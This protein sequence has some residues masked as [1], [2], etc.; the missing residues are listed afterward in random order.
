MYFING[1]GIY[2]ESSCEGNFHRLSVQI[3]GGLLV[4]FHETRGFSIRLVQYLHALLKLKKGCWINLAKLALGG[5][6][7]SQKRDF[8]F[9][10]EEFW[11]AR[12]EEFS[13]CIKLLMH[14]KPSFQSDF[15][16]VDVHLLVYSFSSGM[17]LGEIS[18]AMFVVRS[19]LTSSTSLVCPRVHISFT[20]A[21][22]GSMSSS[23]ITP[24]AR[25]SRPV[26]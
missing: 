23:G 12:A 10:F 5:S 26:S 17:V 3:V 14:F 16:I 9:F 2:H 11:L 13:L 6:Q 19:L 15:G 1:F 22:S 4:H 25:R 20:R 24:I 21:V 7:S 8:W 18:W